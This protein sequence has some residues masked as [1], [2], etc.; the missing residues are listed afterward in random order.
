MSGVKRKKKKNEGIESI[1]M[2]EGRK[3]KNG[4][5]KARC[6]GQEGNKKRESGR[7]VEGP[8]KKKRKSKIKRKS[9]KEKKKK[10]T[11]KRFK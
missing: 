7:K 6:T 11:K 10:K 5:L 3:K 1:N 8:K 4:T 2:R 9:K